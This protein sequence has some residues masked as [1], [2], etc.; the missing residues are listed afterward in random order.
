MSQE[1]H[2]SSL[3]TRGVFA[4]SILRSQDTDGL[5]YKETPTLDFVD[6]I[7]SLGSQTALLSFWISLVK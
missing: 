5:V 6:N 1:F 3:A 7:P 2:I 4:P